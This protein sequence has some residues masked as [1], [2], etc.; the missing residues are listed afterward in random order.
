[1][2]SKIGKQILTFML[3]LLLSII[4]YGCSDTG[5]S[6]SV[7][8]YADEPLIIDSAMC[9]DVKGDQPNGITNKFYS[10]DEQIYLWIYWAN[11]DG[12]SKVKVVWYEEGADVSYKEQTRSFTSESGSQITWFYLDR[13]AGGFSKGEWSL[14]KYDETEFEV[15]SPRLR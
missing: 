13:P 6:S 11:V 7:E 10:N 1:M 4:I 2:R 14:Y 5:G 12:T 15:V 8:P 3:V 9:I